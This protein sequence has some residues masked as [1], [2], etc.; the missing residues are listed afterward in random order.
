M[1][2]KV[3]FLGM[4]ELIPAFKDKKEVEVDFLGG[5]IKRTF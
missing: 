4:F 3:K 2:V 5:Y 1:K